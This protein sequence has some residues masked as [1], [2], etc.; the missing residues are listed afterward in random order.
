MAT[1]EEVSITGIPAGAT[2]YTVD[3][4]SSDGTRLAGRTVRGKTHTAA[5]I[6][7]GGALTELESYGTFAQPIAM[8]T[9]GN[10]VVGSM[11]CA[12]PP[13]CTNGSQSVTRW[14]G[15]AAPQ[16]IQQFEGPSAASSTG[17]AVAGDYFDDVAG[18]RRGYLISGVQ[19]TYIAEFDAVSGLSPDGKT[20]AGRLRT[21]VQAGLWLATTQAM[22][23]IGNTN[24]SSTY[25]SAVSGQPVVATGSGTLQGKPVGFR[26]K[27]GTLTELGVLPG[28][29][30]SY[31]VA[32][33]Y[34]GGTVVGDADQGVLQE[35]IIWT[36]AGSLRLLVDELKAR[37]FEP[38]IDLELRDS[39][40]LS[41]DGKIIVGQPAQQCQRVLAC[42]S[43]IISE[44]RC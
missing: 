36:D 23:K 6:T 24:W 13:T 27:A 42:H 12:D 37:G 44:P 19:V 11:Q 10:V 22:T 7:A 31:P 40:F 43:E 34:D 5:T 18:E 3:A 29:T 39:R 35:A 21:G 1:Y 33:S 9:N 32:I 2:F 15:S 28:G 25:I 4:M 38:P 8:S 26:W 14:T 41:T 30:Y 16:V 20:V 17:A